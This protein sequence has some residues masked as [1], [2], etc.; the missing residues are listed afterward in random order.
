MKFRTKY[1]VEKYHTV[2]LQILIP[3]CP[4]FFGAFDKGRSVFL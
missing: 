3:V 2:A 1:S 4:L